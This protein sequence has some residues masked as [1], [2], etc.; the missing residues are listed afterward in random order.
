VKCPDLLG[1]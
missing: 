1:G